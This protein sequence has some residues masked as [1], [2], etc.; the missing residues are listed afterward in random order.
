M[1]RSMWTVGWVLLLVAV[2]LLS[3]FVHRRAGRATTRERGRRAP[4]AHE[5]RITVNGS[6]RLFLMHVPPSY[7]S[8]RPA[9]LVFVFHGGGGNAESIAARIGFNQLAD[10]HGFIVV[11]PDG[12]KHNWN[13]GRG[14]TDAE[15]AGMDDIAFVKALYDELGE[16]FTID[17]QRIYAAGI[18]NGGMFVNRI[19]CELSDS[20]A[21]IASVVG[22]LPAPL[23]RR[24]ASGRPISVLGIFGTDDPVIPWEGGQVRAGDR[25]P[26]LGVEATIDFW[27]KRNGCQR[28]GASD[29]LPTRVDDGTKVTRTI[30]SECLGKREVAFYR[31]D[32]GGH[33]WPPIQ[34]RHRKAGKSSKNLDATEIIW[35]FF[36]RK[37]LE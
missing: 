32:G 10:A 31:I 20:F 7:N 25:G 36:S 34:S 29:V 3:G 18:S 4:L 27:V 26:I 12:Y 17:R 1:R 16:R 15:L 9:P 14:T 19:G 35:T 22:P 23:A 6:Q 33:A 11:Y 21:A 13:D 28:S 2:V 8:S 30:Y 24:C 5:D 37:T